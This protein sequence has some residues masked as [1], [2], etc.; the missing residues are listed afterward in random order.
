MT[1]PENERF[2]GRRK[3]RPLRPGRARA[4]EEHLPRLAVRLEDGK[5]ILPGWTETLPEALVLEVGFGAG[6]HLAAMA[7][8]APE[9]GFIGCEPFLNGVARLVAR[10][11][12][13]DIGNIRIWPDDARP[14]IDVLP[15]ALFERIY[16]LFPDPWPKRRHHGRRFIGPDTLPRLARVLKPGGLL[17][18]AS[19]HP[20]YIAW[21]LRH[22]RAHGAFEWL[23]RHPDDWRNRP[24]DWPE[25]RYDAKARGQGLRPSYLRFR[26]VAEGPDRPG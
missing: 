17:C 22:V 1:Q 25:S 3:G 5:A 13:R 21:M 10:I 20:A 23:A 16:V 14:L 15:D 7:E 8:A 19:D 26:R 2:Y 24:A 18:L 9:T 12:E 11:A 4:V 6:E